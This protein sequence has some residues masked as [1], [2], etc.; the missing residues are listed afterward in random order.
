MFELK[1]SLWLMIAISFKEVAMIRYSIHSIRWQI[2]VKKKRG[3]GAGAPSKSAT[4]TKSHISTA[5]EYI[6]ST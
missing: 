3:G 5:D 2:S 6:Q 1:V 4:D